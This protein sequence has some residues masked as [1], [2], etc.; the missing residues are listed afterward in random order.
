MR[1]RM[2][3]ASF[4]RVF[5][6]SMLLSLMVFLLN[7]SGL[8]ARDQSGRLRAFTRPLEFDY[9]SWTLESVG[10]KL[11]HEALNADSYLPAAD[12]SEVV[13]QYLHLL[14]QIWQV[15]DEIEEMYADPAVQDPKAASAELNV[16]LEELLEERDWL[17]PLAEAVL[18]A[19]VSQVA[20]DAGLSLGGQPVPPVLFH[21]TPPPAALIV[22]PRNVIQQD[23]NISISPGLT[24]EEIEALEASVDE[25]LDVSSLVVGIGGIGVYPTMVMET[26]NLSWLAE[27]VAHEWIHNYLTLRPLGMRYLASHELRTMNEMAASIAGMELGDAVIARYYPEFLPQGPSPFW[28]QFGPPAPREAEAF[29][30]RAEMRETRITTEQLLAENKIEEAE[31]YMELRRQFLWDNGYH[32]RKLNQAYFAFYGAY[33]DASGLPGA[34][35]GEDPVA[36]AVRAFRDQSEN[37][38]EFINRMAWMASYEALERAILPEE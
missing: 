34:A 17:Q 22:S 11:S 30:Y 31:A 18:E 3:R 25:A 36:A 16:Q 19:Q 29:N 26:T 13:V 33:A 9:I 7:S 5:N 1:W 24:I 21:M 12:Q 20:A 37:L 28:R 6:L 15:Q 27:V 38:A 10:I 2:F 35:A 14:W 4:S 8:V 23:D 32:I